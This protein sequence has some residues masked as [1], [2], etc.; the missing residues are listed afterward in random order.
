M[1]RI[2]TTTIVAAVGSAGLLAGCESG[3]SGTERDFGNSARQVFA[4]QV[5]DPAA[6]LT[7]PAAPRPSPD[8][9]AVNAAIESMRALPGSREEA[10]APIVINTGGNSR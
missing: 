1:G 6:G 2:R 8:N 7:A 4:A 10:A 5:N 3:P 9:D